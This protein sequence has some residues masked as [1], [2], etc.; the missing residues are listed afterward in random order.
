MF[1]RD[2]LAGTTELVSVTLS[3]F[4]GTGYSSSISADG[5]YVAFASG[6]SNL[7]PGDTNNEWDVFVQAEDRRPECDK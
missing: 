1:V 4:P 3:G 6:A 5:R 7:V 2:R